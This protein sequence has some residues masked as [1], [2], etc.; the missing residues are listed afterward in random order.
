MSIPVKNSFFGG[1]GG[2]G[3]GGGAAGNFQKR[4]GD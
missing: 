3:G 1:G 2:G 4:L